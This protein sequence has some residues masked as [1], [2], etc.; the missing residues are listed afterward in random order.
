M[1]RIR[2]LEAPLH[3]TEHL[4]AE[5]F[6]LTRAEVRVTAALAEGLA[7]REI[8]ERLGVSFNT[9]RAQLANIFEKTGVSR[10]ADLMRLI[11]R[12]ADDAN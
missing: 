3:L 1:V 5:V 8:G 11:S 9:V 4:L 2:D 12:M 6:G 7:P 10:Q